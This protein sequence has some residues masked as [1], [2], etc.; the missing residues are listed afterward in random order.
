MKTEKLTKKLNTA[1]EKLSVD[2]NKAN[3]PAEY[4]A[5]VC[6]E[7]G[8]EMIARVRRKLKLK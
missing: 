5:R 3:I 7:E 1:A 4:F 8:L 6:V 2:S